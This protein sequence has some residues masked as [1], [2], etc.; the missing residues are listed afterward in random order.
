MAEVLPL[1]MTSSSTI[2]MLHSRPSSAEAFQG[3]QQQ[4]PRLGQAPRSMYN[5]SNNTS[6]KS[7]AAPVQP[8]AF[9]ATPTLKPETRAVSASNGGQNHLSVQ[10]A[11]H[12]Q[13]A[14]SSTASSDASS[15]KDDSVI[16]TQAETSI[17]F[18]SS[19]DL[20]LQ[21]HRPT[22][23]GEPHGEQTPTILYP[24]Q[25]QMV[26]DRP[27]HHSQVFFRHHHRLSNAQ[28]VLTAPHYPNL[29]AQNWRSD[30]VDAA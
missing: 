17:N 24:R 7:Q 5:G 16:G 22:A 12:S 13:S 4:S 10:R 23:T 30:T 8:Y 26:Q 20:S 1:P 6:Y 21:S 15:A 9:Q 19:P 25:R 29:G 11:G 18:S 27:R 28:L 2:T 14:S 3:P